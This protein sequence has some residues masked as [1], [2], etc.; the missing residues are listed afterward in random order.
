MQRLVVTA[1]TD[2]TV[3]DYK[4]I[5]FYVISQ[6]RPAVFERWSRDMM[7][8]TDSPFRSVQAFLWEK[9]LLMGKGGEKYIP[10]RGTNGT[11]HSK[12]PLE[13][14]SVRFNLP[15]SDDYDMS[16]PWI[17]KVNKEGKIAGD[18]FS[19]IDDVRPT[20]LDEDI[21]WAVARIV[22]SMMMF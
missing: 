6:S 8:L 5:A 13:W 9:E 10:G 3:Y 4:R 14:F 19:Y 15:T 11:D 18:L 16:M 2:N 7:G 12:N 22:G 20:G 21:C 17:Y 1:Q